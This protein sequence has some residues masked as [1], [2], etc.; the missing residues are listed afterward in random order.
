M[1]KICIVKRRQQYLQSR[2]KEALQCVSS[3][4]SKPTVLIEN[5][6]VHENNFADK[7][8]S[9]SGQD[10]SIAMTPEQSIMLQTSNYIKNILNGSSENPVFKI[11]RD[12]DGLMVLTFHLNESPSIR[13][14]RSDQVCGML[15]ISR[16]LLTRLIHE[17]KIK[18]Y[19][20]GRLRRFLLND[21]LE[22]LTESEDFLN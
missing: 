13:M 4:P 17:N 15:Q 16:S 12:P 18:S 14:L 20:I 9:N 5:I 1:E 22:Y 10:I 6:S 21:I 2:N 8:I 3:E 11:K 19:K 7:F